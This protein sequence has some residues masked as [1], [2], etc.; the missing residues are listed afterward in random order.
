M[1]YYAAVS[2]RIFD[3]AADAIDVFFIGNDFGSQKGPL[4]SPAQFGRFMLPHLQR[5]IDLG[6]AYG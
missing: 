6:H 1:D 3:A 2:R 5:L 4:L